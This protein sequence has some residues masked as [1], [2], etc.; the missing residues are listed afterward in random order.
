MNVYDE[1]CRK[2]A[3]E[4][5]LLLEKEAA[6]GA[7]PTQAIKTKYPREHVLLQ[8]SKGP[9]VVS[10]DQLVKEYESQKAM[11]RVHQEPASIAKETSKLS[12]AG[13]KIGEF[14][15]RHKKALAISGLGLVGAAA[16]GTGAYMYAKNR[17]QY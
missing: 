13:K 4:A 9:T 5:L 2:V 1:I 10:V 16:L 12:Q 11:G 17:N 6:V 3:A 8:T 14:I 15:G 7:N